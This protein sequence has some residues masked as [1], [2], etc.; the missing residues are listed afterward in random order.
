MIATSGV[1]SIHGPN[2]Q[3]RLLEEEG[4]EVNVGIVG[5]SRVTVEEWGWFPEVNDVCFDVV[6]DG[7]EWGA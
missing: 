4:I 5:E 6:E 1:I 7:Q 3:Q 2:A